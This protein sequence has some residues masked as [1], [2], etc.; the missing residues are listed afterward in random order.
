[1]VAWKVHG[2]EKRRHR[3][4]FFSLVVFFVVGRGF[5]GWVVV[6]NMMFDGMFI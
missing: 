5:G 6:L 3:F 1:M 4:W 2:G